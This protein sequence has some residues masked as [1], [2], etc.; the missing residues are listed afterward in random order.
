M[1]QNF[2][3]DSLSAGK[4]F[5]VGTYTAKRMVVRIQFVYSLYGQRMVVR[6]QSLRRS[7]RLAWGEVVCQKRSG[8]SG[9]IFCC[10]R[11]IALFFEWIQTN[12]CNKTI[13]FRV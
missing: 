10:P 4:L 7:V 6:I 13:F 3:A 2:P 9:K 1:N 8:G 12:V 5:R 11:L